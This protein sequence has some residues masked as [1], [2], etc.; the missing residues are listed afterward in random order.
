MMLEHIVLGKTPIEREPFATGGFSTTFR[1]F[2]ERCFA[3]QPEDRSTHIALLEHPFVKIAV[4]H[5]VVLDWL[6][7]LKPP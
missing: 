3:K 1:S 7:T 2:C 6:A 5:D 4:D